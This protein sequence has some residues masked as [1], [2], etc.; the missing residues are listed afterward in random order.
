MKITMTQTKKKK[1]EEEILQKKK[2]TMFL[3]ECFQTRRKK[4][5]FKKT[6]VFRAVNFKI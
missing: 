5:N 2:K 6:I 3:V 1:E 4:I